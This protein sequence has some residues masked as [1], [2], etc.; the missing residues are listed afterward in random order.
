MSTLG[1]N[2]TGMTPLLTTLNVSGGSPPSISLDG[3]TAHCNHGNPLPALT[4]YRTSFRSSQE[5]PPATGLG[6]LMSSSSNNNGPTPSK[7]GASGASHATST[8][9]HT[10][11]H[12]QHPLGS[13][14]REQCRSMQQDAQDRERQASALAAAGMA[15]EQMGGT[16]EGALLP[17]GSAG[18]LLPAGSAGLHPPPTLGNPTSG[19]VVATAMATHPMHV[20]SNNPG[21][22]TSNTNNYNGSSSA[23]NIYPPRQT[24][25]TTTTANNND[26]CMSW[27]NLELNPGAGGDYA[28]QGGGQPLTLEEMEMDFAHLFDPSVE[29]ENM[30][31]EGSGWPQ[32]QVMAADDAGSE[33][34]ANGDVGASAVAGGMPAVVQ[35]DRN[36][37]TG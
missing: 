28:Q 16:T 25:A 19:R 27:S 5:K 7:F 11:H 24:V 31:T 3:P 8:L 20:T 14:S 33:A 23:T 17:A 37:K 26:P 22:Y 36:V 10:L 18:V 13:Y 15:A 1:G 6:I 4:T 34:Y 21:G 30:Q 29:W 9:H 12:S 2:S 35:S 32:L